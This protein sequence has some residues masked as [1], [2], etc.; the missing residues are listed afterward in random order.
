MRPLMSG[1]HRLRQWTIGQCLAVTNSPRGNGLGLWAFWDRLPATRFSSPVSV[2]ACAF[3]STSASLCRNP[4]AGNRLKP[5]GAAIPIASK[6][7]LAATMDWGRDGA[8]QPFNWAAFTHNQTLVDTCQR[9]TWLRLTWPAALS[10]ARRMFLVVLR[11][12]ANSIRRQWWLETS[13]LWSRAEASAV[14]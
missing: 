12:A 13:S 7:R 11:R 14:R 5:G 3:W 1:G 2:Q 9:S 10:G 8:A 4:P 6:W